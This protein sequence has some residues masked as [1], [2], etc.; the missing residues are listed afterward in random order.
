MPLR[1]F[2][3]FTASFVIAAA[4]A[5]QA[6]VPASSEPPEAT[7]PTAQEQFVP[8]WT[9]EPGWHT[10]LMLRNNYESQNLV[11]IPAVRLSNGT[12]YAVSSVTILPGTVASVNLRDALAQ[13]HPE[14]NT[15][16]AYGSAVLR[17]NSVSN[18]N[19]YSSAMVYDDGHP[20]LYHLDGSQ[21]GVGSA[22]GSHEGI[23]W[24][25][26][27]TTKGYLA[28]TN[29]SSADQN[30][31]LWLYDQAGHVSSQILAIPAKQTLRL[32][33]PELISHAKLTGT[34]G[35]L[36]FHM[37]QY[38]N[39]V[40]TT[41][42]LYD[43]P[44]GF[45]AL[46][47]TFVRDSSVS[48][49]SHDYAGLGQWV[50]RAPMLAL[51][52]PDPALQLPPQTVLHPQIFL[53]NTT[54]NPAHVQLS[55]HWRDARTSGKSSLPAMNL[56]PQELRLVDVA[57]LQAQNTLPTSAFWSQVTVATNTAP[58]E[59]MAV[60]TSYDETLRYGAQTPF[61][62][63]MAFH[64]EG[65]M[66]Q[67]DPT[68][69]TIIAAG[70]GS[71]QS[72]KARLTF[73]YADGA[74]Q[75]R[76]EQTIAPDDQMWVDMGTLIRNHIPDV[77][78]NILPSD[79]TMG[80][81]QLRD[82]DDTPRASLYE[83]KVVTDKTYGHATY[84]CMVCCGY[85]AAA[86]VPSASFTTIDGSSYLGLQGL[87]ACGNGF[88]DLSGYATSWWS[89]NTAILSVQ[90]NLI[91]GVSVGS[92]SDH[93]QLTNIMYGPP[94]YSG[95]GNP[96]PVQ[97]VPVQGTGTAQ[98]PT[99]FQT[100]GAFNVTASACPSGSGGSAFNVQYYVADQTGVRINQSGMTPLEQVISG[101]KVQIPWSPF[102]TPQ[103]T[104]ADGSFN[105]DPVGTCFTPNPAQNVCVYPQQNFELKYSTT[106][107]INTYTNR[108]DCSQGEQINILGNLPGNNHTYTQGTV[109]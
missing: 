87:D 105:D 36:S 17:Y 32:S 70:N 75:Y 72:V 24:L 4:G 21:A 104:L 7:A 79:L 94:R 93:A 96:C 63:Q 61:S 109:H 83:G 107:S 101:G 5:Q 26:K 80:A 40:S 47:K 8:Y 25:P 30:G 6:I 81:Y 43:E 13:N 103:T 29:M 60:A 95:Q 39:T 16:N 46:M 64:L 59:V 99:Y 44:L 69:D 3:T 58:D 57:G 53:R 98:M 20:I 14:L 92:T 76:M 33:L 84:G 19:L 45:S 90:P 41:V 1:F 48:L 11:V 106:Y 9:N 51:Q 73:F 50:T 12:E 65:G 2:A 56:K 77:Q 37:Q 15:Q 74:K 27:S 62:D 18:A 55:F 42:V 10:E 52:H 78:G 67:V 85:R 28:L 108:K 88:A 86:F 38:L 102:S 35:G 71:K 22:G 49:K 66:W 54:D 100:T 82:L 68:H 31:T 34:Y 91:T 89:G 23:W 97:D